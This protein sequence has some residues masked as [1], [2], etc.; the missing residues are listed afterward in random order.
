[1][2]ATR[3]KIKPLSHSGI[4]RRISEREKIKIKIKI[5]SSRLLMISTRLYTFGMPRDNAFR[6]HPP[7]E[8]RWNVK[9]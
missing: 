4:S 9:T 8:T 1:M 3:E 6:S 7:I 5:S 2:H